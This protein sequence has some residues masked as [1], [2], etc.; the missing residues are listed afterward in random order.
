LNPQVIGYVSELL[1]SE[2]HAL[3]VWKQP[4]QMKKNRPGVCLRYDEECPN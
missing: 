2:R 4:I 1:R 3:D